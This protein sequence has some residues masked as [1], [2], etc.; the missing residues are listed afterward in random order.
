MK[1][2]GQVQESSRESRERITCDV[3]G[4]THGRG[5]ILCLGLER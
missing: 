1:R 4:D 2:I 5:W 3:P